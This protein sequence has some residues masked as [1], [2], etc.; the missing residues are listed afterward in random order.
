MTEIKKGQGQL[1]V[2]IGKN[3]NAIENLTQES[4][5]RVTTGENVQ[6]Y[7]TIANFMTEH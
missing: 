1:K 5:W 2:E 3:T 6:S 4:A 7:Q